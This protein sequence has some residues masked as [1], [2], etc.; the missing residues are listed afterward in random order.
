MIK[1]WLQ[2]Q[3]GNQL[4]QYSTAYAIAQRTKALLQ[5]ITH[6][7]SSLRQRKSYELWKFYRLN[8][9]PVPY[10]ESIRHSF[11]KRLKIHQAIQPEIITHEYNGLGFKPEILTLSGDIVLKGWFQS[12][13]YFNDYSDKLRMLLNPRPL[14]SNKSLR[15]LK[16]FQ[17]RQTLVSLHVRRGDYLGNPMFT[18]DLDSYYRSAIRLIRSSIENPLFLVFSDDLPWCQTAPFLRA[19]DIIFFDKKKAGTRS[20]AE[21]LAVM[22]ICAHSIIANSTFSWWGAWLGEQKSREVIMPRRWLA[23][24]SADDCGIA[25]PGWRQLG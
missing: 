8:L 16:N 13:N 11:H 5:V 23:S 14:L 21:E 24:Y 25:V 12:V 1:V 22:S 15:Y 9:A 17:E 2:G 6:S 10:G 19:D 18:L 20:G 3:L 7:Y 4:F